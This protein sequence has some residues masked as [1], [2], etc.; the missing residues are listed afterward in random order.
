VDRFD[1]PVPT[2]QELFKEHAVAPFFV[3]QLF[4]VGLWLMDEY[5][6]YSLFTLFMLI[7]FE[8]TVVFQ[9]VRTLTEFRSMS[10]QPYD[11]L[12]YRKNRWI[13]VSTEDLLPGD[14]CS[15]VRSTGDMAV[16][17]DMVLLDGTCIVNE[18]MLSGESTPQGKESI[19]LREPNDQ[20]DMLG[21]DK[22]HIV[23][24]GTKVL[25]VTPPS[26]ESGWKTPD[27]GCIACVL[28]TGFGTAQAC[29]LYPS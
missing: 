6:Y 14:V 24:G 27:G 22:L 29:C 21:G 20:L 15:V 3:F 8:S 25:Q 9:R 7:M 16:P 17:C 28:R 11:L 2:F 10:I 5:W 18:A 26:L 23:F 19:Q 4:C 1:I 13:R 12:V